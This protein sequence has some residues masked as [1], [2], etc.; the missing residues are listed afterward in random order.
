V[1]N[2]TIEMTASERDLFQKLAKLSAKVGSVEEAMRR[3]KLAGEDTRSKLKQVSDVG[4][5]AFD[6]SKIRRF[7]G[8]LGIATTGAGALLSVVKLIKDEIANT[9]DVQAKA[10]QR[11]IDLQS[12][13]A[14]LLRNMA[15][16]TP[17]ERRT[18]LEVA[19]KIARETHV[20]EKWITAALASA[21]SAS[22]GNLELA[23]SAVRGAAMLF[24][25]VP[26]EI[27][28]F[29][30]STMDVS[31]ATKS[32][33]ALVNQGV[34]ATVAAMSR[35]VDPHLQAKNIPQALIGMTQYGATVSEAG[36][37][38]AAVTSGAAE[39]TGDVSRTGVINLTQRID[40]MF[41]HPRPASI[42]GGLTAPEEEKLK[43][44][45]P[46]AKRIIEKRKEGRRL[47][48]REISI[49]EE[50]LSLTERKATAKV[51]PAIPAGL[52]T[53]G[54]R[55]SYLQGHPQLVEE[56]LK[57]V[58]I[59]AQLKAPIRDILT[60]RQSDVARRYAEFVRKIPEDTEALRK[61]G[62][63]VISS[64][65]TD[66]LFFTAEASRILESGIDQIYVERPDLGIS[67]AV[68][69]KLKDL[70]Q[71]A[72]ESAL[73]QR[74]DMMLWESGGGLSAARAVP[75]AI[76]LLEKRRRELL[77]TRPEM[78]YQ[79]G[80]GGFV[81]IPADVATPEE[82][83]TAEVLQSVKEL[84]ERMLDEM[85]KQTAA[86]EKSQAMQTPPT[87]AHPDEDR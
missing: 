4:S 40:E 79:M 84:L 6:A 1:G 62:K 86:S 30:G 20:N 31:K 23:T 64:I 73:S 50:Y 85:K 57:G 13:R 44:I 43:L 53:F 71:A 77:Y 72:G 11:Q 41:S 37:F 70:L 26:Q 38:L 60:N 59:R 58:D 14:N 9:Q 18:A 25:D 87:L 76:D 3:V 69:S 39:F 35:I 68:R 66:P 21:Y 24:P 80:T 83:K 45:T 27:G 32:P 10:M 17:Q 12:A 5:Q 16:A 22:G 56:L 75:K 19:A 47:S 29:A 51:I 67:G 61:I 8:Q 54:E 33:N 82:K 7:V 49:W 55:L 46:R 36:A 28:A 42:E 74:I 78:S 63:G 34:M 52:N 48:E 15:A 2:V 65:R 81:S